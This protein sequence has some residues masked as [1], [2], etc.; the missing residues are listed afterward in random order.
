MGNCSVTK[1][2]STKNNEMKINKL[3]KN[4]II[5]LQKNFRLFLFKKNKKK[6]FEANLIKKIQTEN[7]IINSKMNNNINLTIITSSIFKNLISKKIKELLSGLISFENLN[8]YTIKN[9]HDLLLDTNHISEKKVF[10]SFNNF[11]I[12]L[13]PVM[14]TNCINGNKN[15]NKNKIKYI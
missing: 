1:K 8:N 4:A 3:N 6:I 13:D 10:S 15:K 2:H 7:S 12:K 14:I 11:R 5:K 9:F